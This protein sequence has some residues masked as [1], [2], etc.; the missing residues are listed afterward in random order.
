MFLSLKYSLPLI[1][2]DISLSAIN[3]GNLAN[4]VVSKRDFSSWQNDELYDGLVLS[5]APKA[6]ISFF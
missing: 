3:F 2:I 5:R 1:S 6:I 4:S